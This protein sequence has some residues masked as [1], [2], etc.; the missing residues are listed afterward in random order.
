MGP[1]NQAMGEMKHEEGRPTILTL[2]KFDVNQEFASIY[3]IP[4]LFYKPTQLPLFQHASLVI[5][6]AQLRYMYA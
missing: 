5:I 1:S 2:Q 6:Y 4:S 3:C